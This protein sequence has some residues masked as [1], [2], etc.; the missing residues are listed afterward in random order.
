MSRGLATVTGATGFLGRYLVPALAAD[1][2]RIRVLARRDVIHPLW[3]DLEVEVV[4]GDLG[5]E[6]ALDRICA[7]ADV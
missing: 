5:D 1:G 3:R 4:P 2:W 6:R 7:G